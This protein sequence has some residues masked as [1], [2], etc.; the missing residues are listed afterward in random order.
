MLGD[1]S[2][3][4]R[5]ALA[6][7]DEQRVPLRRELDF[8]HRYLA[9]EQARFGDRLRVE[10][11]VDPATLDACVPTF[12]LQPL[13]ENAIKHGIE[14]LCAPGVV[15]INVSRVGESL[16]IS[17]SDSGPGINRLLQTVNAHGVGLANTR[18]RLVALYPGAHEFSIRNNDN[19]GCVVI[20][21]IPFQAS[22]PSAATWRL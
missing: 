1:V 17:I 14:P 11:A 16:R 15:R 22:Q 13:V 4:L 6:T 12:I 9:I 5:A 20:L 10:Q 18:A 21:T 19:A 7:A 2:E 3:L 8:L